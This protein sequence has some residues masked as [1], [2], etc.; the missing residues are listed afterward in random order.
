[1]AGR[2]E[3]K[4]SAG[5][6][7]WCGGS[8]KVTADIWAAGEARSGPSGAEGGGAGRQVRWSGKEQREPGAGMRLSPAQKPAPPSALPLHRSAPYGL[9]CWAHFLCAAR[10]GSTPPMSQMLWRFVL[11][12][13]GLGRI[14]VLSTAL[15]VEEPL[16]PFQEPGNVTRSCFG[17]F[18]FLCLFLL[19]KGCCSR[20]LPLSFSS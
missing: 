12:Q 15:A 10:S 16:A 18:L 19:R 7:G 3:A 5:L 1:M 2:R 14:K 20:K 4:V 9:L 13:Q 11:E 17:L 6:Q 8:R